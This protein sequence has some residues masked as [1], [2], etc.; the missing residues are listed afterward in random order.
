MGAEARPAPLQLGCPELPG[1]VLSDTHVPQVRTWPF[2]VGQ[3]SHQPH[4]KLQQG[5]PQGLVSYHK[6][7]EAGL[8][9]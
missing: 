3:G 8:R 6:G 5:V 7:N 9:P 2:C 4:C 1:F